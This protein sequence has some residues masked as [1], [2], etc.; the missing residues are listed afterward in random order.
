[1]SVPAG[2]AL[3]LQKVGL[4]QRSTEYKLLLETVASICS[5]S[6]GLP[7]DLLATVA[8]IV[9]RPVARDLSDIVKGKIMLHI[10]VSG[11]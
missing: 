6:G 11:G 9:L 2:N 10:Y 1:M 7:E 8:D 3:L 4:L 5:Q